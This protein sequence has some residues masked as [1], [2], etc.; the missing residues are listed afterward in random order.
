[1][2]DQ[3]FIL[4]LKRFGLFLL[5]YTISF[6]IFFK[7]LPYTLPFV[8]AIIIALINK[9]FNNLLI[10][11]FKLPVSLS[12]IITT[13]I[14]FSVIFY[15][16][17]LITLKLITEA[18]NLLVKVPSVDVIYPYI[19]NLLVNL[20][21]H[22]RTLDPTIFKNIQNNLNSVFLTL[23]NMTQTL[24]NSL[25][26]FAIKLPSLFLVIVITFIATYF[27]SKDINSYKI[28]F[29]KIFNEEG[30]KSLASF[31]LKAIKCL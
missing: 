24:L 30:K 17:T 1:M 28:Q 20:E 9:P 31:P 25:L 15:F 21:K 2:F 16:L 29:T 23:L 14:T 27:M 5:I 8:L 7:T 26:S 22:L 12:S 4:K 6:F 10:R 19:Q 3:L 13:T 18:K 11:K